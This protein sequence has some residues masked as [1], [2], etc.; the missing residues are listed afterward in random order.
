MN[1]FYLP[2]F[3]LVFSV[4]AQRQMN[5]QEFYFGNDL[6]YVNEMEDCGVVY[7]K[8]GQSEDP[9]ALFAQHGCNLVRLRLWHTPSWYD[10]LN[11][12]K[13]YSDFA[14]VRKSI[15]RAKA[16]GMQVLL[17][18][19]LSDN[20]ADPGKQRVP[21]AWLPVVH[22][23]PILQDS[24]YDYIYKTLD[25]LNSEGL[26]P[27]MV[28]IGNETN[29]GILLSPEDDQNGW[30]L[31][32]NRNAALFN[33]AIQAVRNIQQTSGKPIKV[34]LHLADPDN[35]VWLTQ[36]F[37]AHGV[38]D[39][40]VIGISYYWPWHQPTD[41]Q[42]TAAII[43]NLKTTYPNK[44]VMIFETSYPWTFAG[45]DSATN[46]FTDEH[47]DY[48]PP[49]PQ[50]QQAWMVDLTQAVMHAGGSGVVYWEPAWVSSPCW[51]QWGKGSHAENASFFDF[52]NNL[53]Q[54]GGIAWMQHNYTSATQQLNETVRL[55]VNISYHPDSNWLML[56]TVPLLP[57]GR[58]TLQITDVAGRILL[59]TAV[60]EL[61][62]NHQSKIQLNVGKLP[63][64]MLIV[65][66]LNDGTPV[67]SRR[68][69]MGQ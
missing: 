37:I 30:V 23:L 27:E 44:E 10:T 49:S 46:I 48:A 28:Q 9:F 58:K 52:E 45:N 62:L 51:T 6:S 29:K 13:R 34:A 42:G 35:A 61:R 54:N 63:M 12:G 20:W 60:A 22:N 41:I 5:G 1:K 31:D 18:F 15:S 38:T 3:S 65:T 14:D 50:T 64:E 53:L 32:W 43:Q 25:Q 11:N 7:K 8:N 59:N 55:D 16:H 56:T 69:V 2:F 24:L 68:V 39:F 17:D 19:H 66:V 4:L 57:E 36:E 67:F 21:A 33:T 47:P 26:S 40:D